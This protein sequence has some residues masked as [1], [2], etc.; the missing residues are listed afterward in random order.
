MVSGPEIGKIGA[1]VCHFSLAKIAWE[2][3][4]MPCTMSQYVQCHQKA[5]QNRVLYVNVRI[6]YVGLLFYSL[7][8]LFSQFF[9]VV[10]MVYHALAMD[11]GLLI[12]YEICHFIG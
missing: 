4:S 9:P 1:P 6:S 7:F 5:D 2:G 10:A 8:V 11:C 3:R 12:G